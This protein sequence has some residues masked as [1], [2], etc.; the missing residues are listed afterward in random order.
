M[1]GLFVGTLV[2]L[3]LAEGLTAHTTGTSG[4]PPAPAADRARALRANAALW[5]AGPDGKLVPR[6]QPVGKRVALTFDDGPDP[7]WTPEIADTLRRL[8]VPAT[9]F[10]VGEH[11]VENPGVI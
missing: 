11:V 5:V 4:T 9:F 1:L 2:L 7:R 3:L 8:G 10:L 6:E